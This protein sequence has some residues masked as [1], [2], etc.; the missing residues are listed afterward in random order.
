MHEGAGRVHSIANLPEVAEASSWGKGFMATQSATRRGENVKGGG[1]G[2]D[3]SLR[4]R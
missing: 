1:G 4:Y 2:R 3:F